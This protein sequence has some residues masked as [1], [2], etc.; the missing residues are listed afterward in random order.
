MKTKGKPKSQAKEPEYIG[1]CQISRS[2][3]GGVIGICRRIPNPRKKDGEKE[4]PSGPVEGQT[5]E[6]Y[7]GK[8]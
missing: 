2:G 8:T 4:S 1:M 5:S 7:Q 6:D 3:D